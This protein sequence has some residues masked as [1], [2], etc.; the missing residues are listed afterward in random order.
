[1]G[2]YVSAPGYQGV[3]Y[4]PNDAIAGLGYDDDA[5]AGELGAYVEAPSYQAVGD[6]GMY[7][8]SHLDQ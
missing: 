8:A 6:L 3:G 7:G 5:L 1:V 4:D 2:A